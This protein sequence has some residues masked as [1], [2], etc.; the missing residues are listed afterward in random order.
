MVK[1]IVEGL[2]VFCSKF[3]MRNNF[4]KYFKIGGMVY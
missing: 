1:N 2:S 4:A 3:R